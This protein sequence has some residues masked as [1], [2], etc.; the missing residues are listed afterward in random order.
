MNNLLNYSITPLIGSILYPIN[1]ENRKQAL[2]VQ[3]KFP[4]A[5]KMDDE[6]GCQWKVM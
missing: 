6:D 5:K 4:P 3:N 1:I 2:I